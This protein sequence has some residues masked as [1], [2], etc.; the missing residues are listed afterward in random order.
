MR[1]R[2]REPTNL[3]G[4]RVRVSTSTNRDLIGIS[5]IVV[6]ETRDT[7]VLRDRKDRSLRVPK[8]ICTFEIL[9]SEHIREIEGRKLRRRFEERL[10][11]G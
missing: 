3:L 2:K 1:R 11:Y 10:T 9:G 6:D 4:E 7:L 5:G 8:E